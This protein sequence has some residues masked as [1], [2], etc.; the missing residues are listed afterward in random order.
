M[1]GNST[2][3]W[4]ANIKH[5][6]LL[7][8]C[9]GFVAKFHGDG[10]IEWNTFLGATDREWASGIAVDSGLNIYVAGGDAATNQAFV[11][12]IDPLGVFLW[13][14][15]LGGLNSQGKALTID[16]SDHLYVAGTSAGT[17]GTPKRAYTQDVDTFV[18]QVAPG[19]GQ[20]QW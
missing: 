17:W 7:A 5:G 16:A 15:A 8:G 11:S 14:T 20:I 6:C 10:Q 12:K 19:T 2:A 9:A 3:S 4:G 1:A 13:D 18:A